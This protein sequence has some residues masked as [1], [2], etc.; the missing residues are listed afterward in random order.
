VDLERIMQ[1]AERSH[2]GVTCLGAQVFGL[3]VHLE[4]IDLFGLHWPGQ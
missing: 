2:R 1:R 3:T 4:E